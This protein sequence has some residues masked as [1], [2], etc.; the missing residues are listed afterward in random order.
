[1]DGNK[2][3]GRRKLQPLNE[4]RTRQAPVT[5][6]SLFSPVNAGNAMININKINILFYKHLYFACIYRRPTGDYRIE[7]SRG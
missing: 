3:N 7:E 1:V 4:A 5:P 2:V 6:F